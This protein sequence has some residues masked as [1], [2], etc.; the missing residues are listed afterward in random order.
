MI[1]YLYIY[2]YKIIQTPRGIFMSS[3]LFL[4]Y[5][6][7]LLLFYS[8]SI[9]LYQFLSSSPNSISISS[10]RFSNSSVVH[11]QMLLTET[12]HFSR[13]FFFI[14]VSLVRL[15]LCACHYCFYSLIYFI[16]FISF[17]NFLSFIKAAFFFICS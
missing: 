16:H 1:I 4:L 17:P 13:L 15:S 11:V 14:V 2:L 6:L 8:L 10:P 12:L 9:I 7:T 5:T 3:V